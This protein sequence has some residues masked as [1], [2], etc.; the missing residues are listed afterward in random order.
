[1]IIGLILA[2]SMGGLLLAW[3]KLNDGSWF[4][5]LLFMFGVVAGV[6]VVLAGALAGKAS[7]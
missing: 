2:I 7:D 3:L 6:A 1:M 5:G 4:V